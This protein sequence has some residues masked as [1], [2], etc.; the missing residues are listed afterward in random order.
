MKLYHY[1]SMQ[2][3]ALIWQS[4]KLKFSESGGTNDFFER[5][6]IIVADEAVLINNGEATEYEI[7]QHNVDAIFRTI[8]KFKQISLC[9]DYSDEL[10]GYASPMMWG[11]YARA[12]DENGVWQDGVCIEIEESSLNLKDMPLYFGKILYTDNVSMLKFGG[13]NFTK[14]NAIDK[15]LE[16]NKELLFFTKHQHWEHENEYRIVS[17]SMDYLNISTAIT[18]IYVLG[19]DSPSLKKV[20]AITQS[21]SLIVSLISCEADRRTFRGF[22]IQKYR[23]IIQRNKERKTKR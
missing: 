14:E 8:N 9:L 13:Y 3:F 1:T 18:G 17:N 5:H 4:G 2:N 15:Y 20:E 22:N 10:K 23:D 19:M 21:P 7:L 6:K 12:K 16:I 11:Q